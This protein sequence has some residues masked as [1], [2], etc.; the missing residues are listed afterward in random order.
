VGRAADVVTYS[1]TGD[2]L[3]DV[4]TPAIDAS[5]SRLRSALARSGS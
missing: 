4:L 3:T 5:V 2:S 1:T